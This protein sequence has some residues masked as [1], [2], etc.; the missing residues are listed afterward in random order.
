MIPVDPGSPIG[1]V[2][3]QADV[4]VLRSGGAVLRVTPTDA[5]GRF[6][7]RLAPGQYLLSAR[8]T[9]TSM[10]SGGVRLTV[11]AGAAYRLRLWLDSGVRFPV[12]ATARPSPAPSGHGTHYRQGVFGLTTIGPITPVGRPGQPN[13]KPYAA[14]LLV[15]RQDGV[16]AATVRSGATG[17][18]TAP[19]PAG[20]YIVEPLSTRPVLHPRAVPFSI[21]V[22]PG[23]WERV[24]VTY[25]S[26]IR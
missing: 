18:F 12:N 1:W 2:A 6:M 16:L 15:W 23:A 19:L 21:S 5:S 10:V 24:S 25:D 22:P 9:G 11:R 8:R 14:T 13:A 3:A 4:S 26:G 7:L 20:D 17:G